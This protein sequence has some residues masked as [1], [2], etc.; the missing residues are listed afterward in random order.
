MALSD[1]INIDFQVITAGDPKLLIVADTSTWGLIET[2]PSII[3]ITPPNK[4]TEVVHYFSKGKNNVF[5][6]SNLLISS[7]GQYN[8]LADGVYE[9]VVKGSPSTEYCKSRH[10]LKTDKTQLQ[11]DKMYINLAFERGDDAKRSRRTIL[12]ME[13]MIKAAEALVRNGEPTKGM[14]IF[15]EAAR[16]LEN[17]AECEDCE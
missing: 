3:E 17:F 14:S 12:E 1:T 11:L 9:I 13:S 10:Y 8:D 5:N 6:S 7:Q 16:Q 15:V 4:T 2:E